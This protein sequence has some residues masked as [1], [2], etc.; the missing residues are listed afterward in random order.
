MSP[1]KPPGSFISISVGASSSSV[2]VDSMN[3]SFELVPFDRNEYVN[4]RRRSA[5]TL[6]GGHSKIVPNV[7]NVP[8]QVDVICSGDVA[9]PMGP[10]DG[11]IDNIKKRWEIYTWQIQGAI[12]NPVAI[13]GLKALYI[14][15][16]K[17]L[18][19]FELYKSMAAE[20]E[21][22]ITGLT[23]LQ[24]ETFDYLTA[25]GVDFSGLMLEQS[26]IEDVLITEFESSY[27]FSVIEADG[28]RTNYKSYRIKIEKRIIG[29]QSDIS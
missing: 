7:A 18:Q 6:V 15:H 24:S 17:R 5:P 13:S 8:I 25:T 16:K 4:N 3:D 27:E 23:T 29:L 28:S 2:Y 20:M 14:N 9:R 12:S 26:P 21:I 1:L 10:D 19:K 11:H 22:S